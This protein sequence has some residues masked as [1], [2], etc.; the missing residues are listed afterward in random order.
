MITKLTTLAQVALLR[1]GDIVKRYPSNCSDGPQENFDAGREKHI[2]SYQV[3]L[4]NPV[5][6]MISLVSER[7]AMRMCAAPGEIGRL[8]IKGPALVT[9]SV[10]WVQSER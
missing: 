3:N 8:F 4:I 1:V 2:D 7:I 6:K 5:N 9:E 10:W